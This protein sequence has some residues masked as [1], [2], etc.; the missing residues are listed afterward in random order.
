MAPP[1]IEAATNFDIF[2]KC[3]LTNVGDGGLFILQRARLYLIDSASQTQKL[4]YYTSAAS[5]GPLLHPGQSTVWWQHG[6]ATTEGSFKLF[7]RWEAMKTVESAPIPITIR[8][9]TFQPD[10]INSYRMQMLRQFGDRF[11]EVVPNTSTATVSYSSFTF[12]NDPVLI[13]G[14]LYNAFSFAVPDR[15]GELVWSFI[16]NMLDN[17]TWG[18]IPAEGTME[19]FTEFCHRNIGHRIPGVASAGDMG[20]FQTLPAEQLLSHHRYYIWFQCPYRDFPGMN[21]SF[22]IFPDGP[23]PCGEI[24]EKVYWP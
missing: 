4:L 7:A 21:L 1:V 10:D 14:S 2:V 23:H 22:N 13:D 20:I 15:G 24:F 6:R 18:I 8:R 3:K 12:T 9:S 5:G 17:V 11:P 16:I 19:G